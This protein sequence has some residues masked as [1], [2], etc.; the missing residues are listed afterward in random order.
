MIAGILFIIIGIW[1]N[2]PVWYYFVCGW[3]LLL[4]LAKYGLD[5]YRIGCKKIENEEK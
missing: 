5:M 1:L 4:K 2:A 3:M